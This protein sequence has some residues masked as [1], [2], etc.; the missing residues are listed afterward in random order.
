MLYPA[1]SKACQPIKIT[2][3]RKNIRTPTVRPASTTVSLFEICFLNLTKTKPPTTGAMI[4]ISAK[5]THPKTAA[6]IDPTTNTRIKTAA[7]NADLTL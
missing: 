3:L 6:S 1:M 5:N 4:N 7:V 2:A